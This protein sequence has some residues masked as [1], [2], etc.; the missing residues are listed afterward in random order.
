MLPIDARRAPLT[1]PRA[2]ASGSK[3]NV[4]TKG[5]RHDEGIN[6]IE[7]VARGESLGAG[8][9]LLTSSCI[10]FPK[11]QPYASKHE[12][13]QATIPVPEYGGICRKHSKRDTAKLISAK[14]APFE[15]AAKGN[16]SIS[17]SYQA[18]LRFQR[19]A[20]PLISRMLRVHRCA[21]PLVRILLRLQNHTQSLSPREHISIPAERV[22]QI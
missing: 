21:A 8:E 22:W 5:G 6:P 2:S 4:Y 14:L 11:A 9:I 1:E 20:G 12:K 16:P 13:C 19:K 7:W 15:R 17:K 10:R 3:W 18:A